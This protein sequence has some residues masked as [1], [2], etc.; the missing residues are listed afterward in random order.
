MMSD[1]PGIHVDVNVA[2]TRLGAV[3]SGQGPWQGGWVVAASHPLDR[4][5]GVTDEV[6]GLVQRGTA[7]QTQALVALNYN[8]SNALVLDVGVAAGLSRA[9]PDWQVMAG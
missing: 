6:S 9:A 3:D 5:F 8:V 7:A 4:R 2:G 1:Y